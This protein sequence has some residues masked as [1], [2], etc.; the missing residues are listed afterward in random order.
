MPSVVRTC[1]V[2]P[3]LIL[4]LGDLFP[5]LGHLFLHADNETG[6]FGL[7][8]F[9][10][11]GSGF[12]EASYHLADRHLHFLA[13]FREIAHQVRAATPKRGDLAA[14]PRHVIC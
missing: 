11:F 10:H 3:D 4:L 14:Q 7:G 8:L 1:D 12:S 13:A 6:Q 9:G 2:F 5:Q